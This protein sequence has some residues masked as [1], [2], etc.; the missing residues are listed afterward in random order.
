MLFPDVAYRFQ[1]LCPGPEEGEEDEATLELT[2]EYGT[3]QEEKGEE[4]GREK[5]ERGREGGEEMMGGGEGD[6]GLGYFTRANLFAEEV[7]DVKAV[8][9]AKHPLKVEDAPSAKRLSLGPGAG[10]AHPKKPP[11]KATAEPGGDK[12]SRPHPPPLTCT[13]TYH[14][15]HLSPS[16]FK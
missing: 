5:W 9:G 7:K 4:G 2:N 16:L 3:T 10:T 12:V 11:T 8:A 6:Q 13:C 14:V 15:F 1:D